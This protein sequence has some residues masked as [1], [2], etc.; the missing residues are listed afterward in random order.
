MTKDDVLQLFKDKRHLHGDRTFEDM[1]HSN[2]P[3]IAAMLCFDWY[4]P[5][6]GKI[7]SNAR[8]DEIFFAPTVD[9]MIS[10][11]ADEGEFLHLIRCGVRLSE[12][13]EFFCMPV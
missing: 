6:K 5:G 13:G 9:D 2:R 10:A 3:D 7:V 11:G 4:V 1:Q 8:D 12:C